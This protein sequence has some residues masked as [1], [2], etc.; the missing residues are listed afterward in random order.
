[1]SR[2]RLEARD[3]QAFRAMFHTVNAL[4]ARHQAVAEQVR[5]ESAAAGAHFAATVDAVVPALHAAADTLA[6]RA[7]QLSSVSAQASEALALEQS[8]QRSIDAL[9]R[10]GDLQHV[11]SAV[12]TSLHGLKPALER[13]ALPRTITLVEADGEIRKMRA[14]GE[15]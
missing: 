8:L 6:Q 7:A 2:E 15:A 1:M 5:S 13:L 12:E 9:Q 4:M 11:L 10:T 14:N 3:Q